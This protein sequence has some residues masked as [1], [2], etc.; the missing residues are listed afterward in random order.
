M[1]LILAIPNLE[2]LIL[3][4]VTKTSIGLF[5]RTYHLT[6]PIFFANSRCTCISHVH[7]R[8]VFLSFPFHLFIFS[9]S[10]DSRVGTTIGTS[11][12]LFGI[13]IWID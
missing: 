1:D 8:Y 4:F 13:V 3:I 9:V 10:L 6:F 11:K 2:S 7:V 5:N 12:I